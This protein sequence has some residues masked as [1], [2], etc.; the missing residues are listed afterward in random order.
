MEMQKIIDLYDQRKSEREEKISS[1]YRGECPFLVVQNPS[2][3]FYNNCNSINDLSRTNI[4]SFAEWLQVEYTDDLP[5]L[6]PWVGVGV[7]ANAFGCEY[8]WKEN[9]SP[10]THYRYHKIDE[11]KELEYPDWQKSSIMQMVLDSIEDL[12]TKTL[13]KLPISM[14]DTQSPFDTATLILDATEFFTSCYSDEDIVLEFMQKITDLIVEFSK[15]QVEAIGENLLAAPGHIMN[16]ATFL[17]GISISDDNLAVSSPHINEK[18]AMPFNQQ[19]AN[20]FGGLAIH[21]C[22]PWTHTMSLLKNYDNIIMIDCAGSIQ[23]DPS[24]NEPILIRDAM[25]GSGIVTQVR[26]GNDMDAGMK[27]IEE[28]VDHDIRLIIKLE[29]IKE[30]EEENYKRVVD[31]LKREYDK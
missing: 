5:Y 24:P 11:V 31:K 1:F 30:N 14:T 16:S 22:G 2:G 20:A 12:K 17:K 15:I 28:L 26:I 19:I 27:I 23:V 8:F 13:G 7:Y 9:E 18:I 3:S 4:A 25:K 6:E 29:Y 21:S 10:A